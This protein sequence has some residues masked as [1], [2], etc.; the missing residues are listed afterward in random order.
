MLCRVY[1]PA[2]NAVSSTHQTFDKVPC[3]LI[4]KYQNVDIKSTINL[5][6]GLIKD[7]K[8]SLPYALEYHRGRR[9]AECQ[10]QLRRR[11]IPWFPDVYSA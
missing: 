5:G 8:V 4:S 11:H 1:Q 3:M 9:L 7:E 6:I 10:Q 2:S